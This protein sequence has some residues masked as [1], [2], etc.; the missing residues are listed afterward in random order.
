MRA[1]A[2]GDVDALRRLLSVNP[3]LAKALIGDRDGCYRTLLHFATDRRGR[4]PHV[5]EMVAALVEAGANVNA[6]L[7]GSHKETPLHWA[8]SRDDVDAIDALLDAGADIDAP[9][10]VIGEG[11]PFDDARAFRQWR[12]AHRLAERG[13]RTTMAHEAT[14]GHFHRLKD[15]FAGPELPDLDGVSHAFWG[16]CHGGQRRCAEY[17]LE[18]GADLNWIPPWER[19]TPLDAAERAG[20]TELVGWLR[21]RGARSAR[22]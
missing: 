21:G 7:E 2:A 4:C 5:R 15:R 14:L 11:T 19:L 17:L 3:S 22:R 16:A 10:G 12:A 13:A 9:G 6:G 18:K 1:I 8:A 20:A